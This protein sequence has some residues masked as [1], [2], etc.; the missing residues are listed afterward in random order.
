ME[1]A[2]PPR[3]RGRRRRRGERCRARAPPLGDRL[4]RRLRARAA[5]L[6]RELRP[7]VPRRRRHR[8]PPAA[9]RPDAARACRRASVSTCASTTE[10]VGIDREAKQVL[11]RERATGRE[12]REPYDALVLSPGAEP[13]RP[14]VPGVDDP[15]VLTLR[16]LED[17][18]R[19]IAA[20]AAA[21]GPALVVG[22]G[23]IGLE[24][25]EALR[26]RGLGVVLVERLPQV[27]AV[28]DPEMV[29]P[30]ARGAARRTA[31]TCGSGRSVERASSRPR[32]P[33][34]PASPTAHASPAASRCSPW[35][36]GPRRSW[37]ARPA[38]PSARPAASRSTRRCA[39]ATR[40]SGRS[41]TRSRCRTS[42]G[43]RAPSSRSPAPRTARAGSPPTT[44]S[45][46][47]AATRP[48]RGP[49]S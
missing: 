39:R 47:P 15:R 45:G 43:R 32:T 38:S 41:A 46:A 7:A 35:A 3:D 19:V 30:A 27:M 9:A 28:A 17:M 10:V 14:P 34:S 2:A 16:N 31:S 6:V 49:R 20:A 24:M 21:S 25:A 23:Y 44:S 26:Q 12:Y 37:P 5:R 4:D 22:G 8:G 42:S 48:R 18:D 40:R 33:S 13:I 11:V 29:A 1:R 36:C